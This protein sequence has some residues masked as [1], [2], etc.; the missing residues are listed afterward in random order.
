MNKQVF[1]IICFLVIS[2][3]SLAQESESAFELRRTILLEQDSNPEEVILTM[4]ENTKRFR[5]QIGSTI[6]D[7]ELTIEFYDPNGKKQGNFTVG[8]QMKSEK[9]EIVKGNIHKSWQEPLSGDWRVRIIPFETTGEINIE[10]V[11]FE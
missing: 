2:F 5:L 8:T 7:G 11:V 9:R 1:S 10:S 6:S 3:S 4:P